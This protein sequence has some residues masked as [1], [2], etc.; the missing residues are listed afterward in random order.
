MY[1][2]NRKGLLSGSRKTSIQQELAAEILRL[3]R[4]MRRD[5]F[6]TAGTNVTED[7]LSETII[8]LVA[9]MPVKIGERYRWLMPSFFR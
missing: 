7:K 6:S 8:E 2:K 3:A 9:A 1:P 4:A 5:N